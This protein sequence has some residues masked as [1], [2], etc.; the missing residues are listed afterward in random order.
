M[1]QMQQPKVDG[2]A[3]QQGDRMGQSGGPTR[4]WTSRLSW[5]SFFGA[6]DY[7]HLTSSNHSIQMKE[8]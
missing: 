6:P 4:Y 8:G 2:G 1:Q 7:L 3:E 5:G